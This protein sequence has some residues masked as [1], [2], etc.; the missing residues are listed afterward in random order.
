[1]AKKL[2]ECQACGKE[3]KAADL[4]YNEAEHELNVCQSCATAAE[5]EVSKEQLAKLIEKGMTK[6]DAKAK[7]A[8]MN[9]EKR[10]L[11]L[12]AELIEADE[13]DEDDEDI[14][15]DGDGDEDEVE[16]EVATRKPKT[17]KPATPAKPEK[18]AKPA[19]PAKPEATTSGKASSPDK[20]K[21]KISALKKEYKDADADERKVLGA[22]IRKL[23][24]ALAG[25]A[26]PEKAPK[27]AK[28]EKVATP[29]KP[30]KAEKATEATGSIDLE[31]D[32]ATLNKAIGR[33]IK[34]VKTTVEAMKHKKGTDVGEVF[35]TLAK[36]EV[37][38]AVLEVVTK[39][40]AAA[41]KE[42]GF[43]TTKL[44]RT[45]RKSFDA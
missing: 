35:E 29:A 15:V 24:A 31:I 11:K 7:V 9:L 6:V 3:F 21:A 25:N 30:A 18:V 23:R 14:E 32:I 45:A 43:S 27:A 17:T 13:M 39:A 16:T 37:S 8:G 33:V 20:I 5:K 40:Y 36:A 19:K 42:A 10:T 4:A 44:I 38:Q 28:A 12:L 41:A 26:T 22:E 1:M 2:I 34:T